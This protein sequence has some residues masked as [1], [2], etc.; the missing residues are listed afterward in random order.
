[1]NQAFLSTEETWELA[2]PRRAALMVGSALKSSGASAVAGAVTRKF[3]APLCLAALLFYPALANNF[4]G[5]LDALHKGYFKEAA[6]DFSEAVKEG[7][8]SA[9]I[10]LGL[11]S[12]HGLGIP[13]DPEQAVRYFSFAAD[14]GD[15]VGQYYL[16][17]LYQ[18]DFGL[19][20]LTRAAQAGYAPAQVDLGQ[21]YHT[22]F[23]VEQDFE[24]AALW[25]DKAAKAGEPRAY[26]RL[27]VMHY[28][29]QWYPQN[30]KIAAYNSIIA[31]RLYRSKKFQEVQ[32][33]NLRTF[34]KSLTASDLSLIE[35]SAAEMANEVLRNK[36]SSIEEMIM[37]R[38]Y[39]G[40]DFEY[41][42]TKEP[43]LVGEMDATDLF[44]FLERGMAYFITGRCEEA[45]AAFEKADERGEG[46]GRARVYLNKMQEC[47]EP[48]APQGA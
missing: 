34:A 43:V 15:P 2:M 35:F 42:I 33:K 25:Y 29:G 27:A 22:G 11:M 31:L 40:S 45:R 24:A 12:W 19:K 37:T 32:M 5:G 39:L 6:R 48:R 13:R 23:G 46:Q 9:T 38:A 28:Y 47:E 44:N 30:V 3:L 26:D 7:H 36:R 21:R 1:M 18:D 17:T 16:G 14:R 8:S 41:L 4:E 20:H 10:F